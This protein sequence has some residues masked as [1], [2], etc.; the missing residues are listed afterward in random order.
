MTTTPLPE[1][2]HAEAARL[3]PSDDPLDP[4]G[5]LDSTYDGVPLPD[6]PGE[7]N[8]ISLALDVRA[9]AESH[10]RAALWEASKREWLI[11]AMARAFNDGVL[12]CPE[13]STIT[14]LTTKQVQQWIK[15]YQREKLGRGQRPSNRKRPKRRR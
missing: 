9:A 8:R 11:R 1:R 14:G 6:D 15:P 12:T 3:E 2:R 7:A 4:V 13:M 5:R 10:Q